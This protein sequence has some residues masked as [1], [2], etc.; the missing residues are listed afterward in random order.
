MSRS[1]VHIVW[2]DFGYEDRQVAKVFA[3]PEDAK[4][5]ADAMIEH[6]SRIPYPPVS[7]AS[8]VHHRLYQMDMRRWEHRHP[9][10]EF[11]GAHDY[12]VEEFEVVQP[13]A[14]TPPATRDEIRS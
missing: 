12:E 1:T 3:S 8:G 2:A 4:A 5:F 14:L 6:E 13:A 10:I 9:A 11:T 7:D